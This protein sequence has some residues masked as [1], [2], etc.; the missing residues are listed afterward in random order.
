MRRLVKKLLPRA[1]S[2]FISL[3]NEKKQLAKLGRIRPDISNLSSSFNEDILANVFSS[4]E[5]GALWPQVEQE[6]SS[7]SVVETA[8]G[9]N[10]GDRRA[11]YYLTRHLRSKS[12]LEVG[13]H[14][15]ASTIHIVAALRKTKEQGGS[16]AKVT[17]V[18]I[19][20]VN[21]MTAKPWLS[22][23]TK[24]SPK[25]MIQKMGASEWVHFITK[26][27]LEFLPTTRERFDL[28]FLDGD[29]SAKNVYQEIP[30]ALDHLNPNGVI[31][32]HDYFPKGKSLWNGKPPVLGPWLAA[33]RFQS[34]GLQLKILPLG[35][36]PWPTKLDSNITSLALLVK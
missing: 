10:R 34:E 21:D 31:L 23:G 19:C 1:L 6:M 11:I 15:G 20:D 25:E 5:M 27:S 7:F 3:H 8:D 29:H 14:I 18:D 22:W 13:T 33:Q 32:L 4:G 36:L 30:A 28:I 26:P 9:V 17:T 35:K 24:F 2:N 12:A 16:E